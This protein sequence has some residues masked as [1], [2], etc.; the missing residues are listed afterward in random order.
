[1]KGIK[2]GVKN[3]EHEGQYNAALNSN[4]S[5]VQG[6]YFSIPKTEEEIIE[7][8]TKEKEAVGQ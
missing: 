3:I 2:V 4:I 8:L 1:M 5:F 7:Q 6:G